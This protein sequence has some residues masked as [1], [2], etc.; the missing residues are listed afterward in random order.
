MLG[1][2]FSVI[3]QNEYD[4]QYFGEESGFYDNDDISDIEVDSDGYVWILTFSGITRYDGYEFK[5]IETASITHGSFYKIRFQSGNKPYVIDTDGNLFKV[6]NDSIHPLESN[7]FLNKLKTRSS[8]PLGYLDEKDTLHFAFRQIEGEY[9]KVKGDSIFKP[10]NRK[11]HEQGGI[12]CIDKGDQF[13]VFQ[14]S[15]KGKGKFVPGNYINLHYL[16]SNLNI[17]ETIKTKKGK[18]KFWH[19]PLFQK[20]NNGGYLVSNGRSE[21]SLLKNGKI[22]VAYTIDGVVRILEDSKQG[23]WITSFSNKVLYYEEGIDQKVPTD[24]IFNTDLSIALAEDLDGNFWGFSKEKGL[25]MFNKSNKVKKFKEGLNVNAFSFFKER[26]VMANNSGDIELTDL[27][28]HAKQVMPIPIIANSIA[29]T[30]DIFDIESFDNTIWLSKRLGVFRYQEEKWSS[31]SLNNLLNKENNGGRYRL[32]KPALNN[33]STI[34]GFKGLTVFEY[35]YKR[36]TCLKKD[37]NLNINTC[38]KVNDKLFVGNNEGLYVVSEADEYKSVDTILNKIAV[39]EI[40]DWN[41][42]LIISS[43]NN[44]VY[45]QVGIEFQEIKFKEYSLFNSFLCND[46]SDFWVFSEIG[47]FQLNAMEDSSISLSHFN[48]VDF[49]GLKML[50][51]KGEYLYTINNSQ[52]NKYDLNA[53]KLDPL[54]Q[55]IFNLDVVKVNEKEI[56]TNNLK[57]LKYNHNFI[58]INY[59]TISFKSKVITFRYKLNGLTDKWK[60]TK[61]RNILFNSLPSGEYYLEIQSRNGKEPWSNSIRIEINISKPFWQE[62]WF[63]AFSLLVIIIATSSFIRLR[64]IRLKK[65]NDLIIE[66]LKAEQRALRAQINPHFLFNIISSAQYF[67]LKKDTKKANEFLNM[68]S[69]MLRHNLKQAGLSLIAIQQ[70]IDLITIYLK[71]EQFRLEG[72]FEFNITRSDSESILKEEIPQFILQPFIENA[73][74]H[75][76]KDLDLNGQIDIAFEIEGNFIKVV[77]EDNGLGIIQSKKLKEKYKSE[78]QSYGVTIS[79]K[80]ILLYNGNL[81][82]IEIID[83]SIEDKQGTRVV[84]YLKRKNL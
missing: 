34:I 29:S 36:G 25:C 7:D 40:L 23:I 19:I 24:T 58:E 81:K 73:V 65:E 22:S 69:K 39:N 5:Q 44:G 18:G 77:I 78:R 2:N 28:S 47:S 1:I 74:Q 56:S 70:E 55:L 54:N 14:F 76:V 27:S 3:A 21:V 61:E 59:N 12:F 51:I 11:E 50:K 46:G 4:F 43:R 67:I 82:G 79:E 42:T 9:L 49:K 37:F 68:F 60:E 38:Y 64:S 15:K 13:Y 52:L 72:K 31:Y 10:M 75:G 45:R 62:W 20:L 32:I 6:R 84:I 16:D 8:I 48:P 41:G 71:L 30:N 17:L 26:L 57:E 33:D 63:I 66:N 83:L 53:L 80:R 35:N